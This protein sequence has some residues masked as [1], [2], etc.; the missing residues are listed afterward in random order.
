MIF[1]E[2]EALVKTREASRACC[3]TFCIYCSIES[4]IAFFNHLP[5]SKIVAV[6]CGTMNGFLK[7]VTAIKTFKY[8]ANY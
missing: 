6:K 3:P 5:M 8:F 7:N 4:C 2:V 1:S